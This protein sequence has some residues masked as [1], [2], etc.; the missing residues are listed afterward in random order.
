MRKSLTGR[1]DRGFNSNGA[2]AMAGGGVERPRPQP[3]P[4][5]DRHKRRVSVTEGL[6]G[7]RLR[8]MEGLPTFRSC[9]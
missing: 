5:T 7:R 9:P 3:L 2:A 4:L 8:G 1:P 6:A